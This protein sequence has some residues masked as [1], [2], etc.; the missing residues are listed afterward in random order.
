LSADNLETDVWNA[1]TRRSTNKT[2]LSAF[3]WERSKPMTEGAP[4]RKEI[5]Q[6]TS[7]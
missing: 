5:G 2:A 4:T 3:K 6:Q 1:V 7:G